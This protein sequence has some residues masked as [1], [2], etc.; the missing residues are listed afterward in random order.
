[1]AKENLIPHSE[2]T[3]RKHSHY[4]IQGEIALIVTPPNIH[5]RYA[6]YSISKKMVSFTSKTT[7][8]VPLH[9]F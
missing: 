1:M 6:V 5:F 9:V 2:E 4:S 8:F 3:M 7:M